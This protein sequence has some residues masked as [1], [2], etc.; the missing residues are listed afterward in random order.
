MN[1]RRVFVLLAAALLVLSLA[2]C[3]NKEAVV[4]GSD[5]EGSYLDV[6]SLIYQ[7]QISRQLNPNDAEDRSYLVGLSPQDRQLA[8]DEE[9]F[10]VFM[11]ALNKGH[12][13][14]P[15]T[16]DFSITDTQDNVYRPV[17]FGP[18]NVF[19]YRGG[20]IPPGGQLPVLDSAAASN[21]SVEGALVLFKIKISSVGNRPLVLHIASPGAQ[22]SQASVDLDV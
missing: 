21:P 11:L 4:T 16:T 22:P 5:T 8:P 19:A 14:A 2:A 10:A 9:W 13:A 12:K 3:G 7:V 15:A 1:V 18:D 17:P 20:V 6:G